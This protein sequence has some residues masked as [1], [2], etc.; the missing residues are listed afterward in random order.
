MTEETM[1][2][3]QVTD[4]SA[5]VVDSTDRTGGAP[6]SLARRIALR[7]FGRLGVPG[8]EW[9]ALT[10]IA[11]LAAADRFVN[12]PNRFTWNTDQGVE[13]GAIWNAVVTRQL[14]TFGSPAFSTGGTFHHGAL[15]YDLMIPFAWL[16]NGNPDVLVVAIALF[17]MAVIPLVWW[18]A[19]SIGGTSAGIAAA[20]LAAVSPALIDYSTLIWNPVL[21][22]T[23]VALACF[24]A[25]QAWSTGGPRWWVVAAA[26]TALASQSHLTGLVLVFPM[27][28]FFLVALR[29]C[30][31][32]NRRRLIAWGVAGVGLFVLTW[33]P[34]IVSELTHNF[35]ETRAM[36]AFT[37]PGESTADP[38]ARLVFALIRIQAWP[39]TH[40]PLDDLTGGFIAALLIAIGVT[41]GMIWRVTGALAARGPKSAVTAA[42]RERAGLLFIGGSLLLISTTLG[43]GIKELGQVQNINQEQY[44]VVADVFVILATALIVA[45]LWRAAPLRGRPW[46]GHALAVLAMV[47]L[48][49]VGIAHWPPFTASDGGWPSATAAAT[50]LEKDAAAQEFALIDIPSFKGPQEYSYPLTLDGVKLI[51]PADAQTVVILCDVDWAEGCGGTAEAAWIASTLPDANLTLIDRFEPTTGRILSVYRREP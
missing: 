31:A 8:R 20:L 14:P 49:A 5:P 48:I 36:L 26:G 18:T 10:A 1:P 22:E 11:V 33:M 29:R 28:I 40:W 3:N 46:S 51:D 9:A 37:Q 19:R 43:L 12:L 42:R 17:G 24:G 38:I 44:H 35:A 21:V 2:D 39:M 4:G 45:G 32:G 15:F 30:P 16:G 41:A 47:G 50:R 7:V 34:W 6:D 23:G 13:V 27:A 25:W